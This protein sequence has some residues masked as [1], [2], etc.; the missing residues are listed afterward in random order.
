MFELLLARADRARAAELEGE[1]SRQGGFTLIELM[2]VLLII[3]ILLAIAIPTF[4]GVTGAARDRSAQSL[5]TNVLTETQAAYQNAQAYPSTSPVSYYSAT[6]PQFGWTDGTPAVGGGSP[7]GRRCT[8]TNTRCVS[9]MP[10]D[11]ATPSDLEGVILTVMSS[12]NTCWYGVQLQANPAGAAFNPPDASQFLPASG[13]A[14]AGTFFA[15]SQTPAPPG[16]CWAGNFL[17][18]KNWGG[19]YAAAPAN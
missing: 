5:L 19:S 17:S 3:A 11:L 4:L 18:G 8:T 6:D 13:A 15:K 10:V 2:V 16:S 9:V 14:T 1:G 12:T 7:V